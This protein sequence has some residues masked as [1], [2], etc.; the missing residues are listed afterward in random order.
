MSLASI[1]GVAAPLLGALARASWQGALFI[2]AVWVLC[3]LARRLPAALRCA[4]WWTASVKLLVGLAWAA[5]LGLPLLPAA[6]RTARPAA[7]AQDSA[8]TEAPETS[9]A[10][11]AAR[12]A[13]G[14]AS[15][16]SG[17]VMDSAAHTTSTIPWRAVFSALS[18]GPAAPGPVVA[19]MLRA[20][21]RP[22]PGR[23][24]AWSSSFTGLAAA[25]WG[26]GVL[27]Q[28]GWLGRELRRCRSMVRASRPLAEPRA[29]ALVA[30]LRAELG[31][32]RPPVVRCSPRVGSPLIL[33]WPR[34]LVLLP[35][36]LAA[37]TDAELAMALGHELLHL[38]RRDLW[39]GWVPLLAERIFFFHPLAGLAAREYALAREAACDAEVVDRIAPA[40]R[41]YGRLLLKL[42]L[43]PDAAV[44]MS[45]GAA[46]AAPTGADNLKR[47]LQMLHESSLPARAPRRLAR[48]G[49]P[50][51]IV[52]LVVV[53]AACLV[54]FEIV[55][56]RADGAA[57]PQA[58]P[59]IQAAPEPAPLADASPAPAAASSPGIGSP[60]PGTGSPA[61][62]VASA[63]PRA[64]SPPPRAKFSQAA[65]RPIARAPRVRRSD[66]EDQEPILFVHGDS[67]EVM[68]GS[69]DSM[70]R[71]KT[72]RG[73]LGGGDLLWFR[74]GGKEYTVRDAATLKRVAEVL[75]PQEELGRQQGEL[76]GRQGALG[77]KQ[78]ELGAQ[79]GKLGA[80]QGELGAEQARLA[81]EESRRALEGEDR[82][83]RAE[84][85]RAHLE[86]EM[87][88]L[89]K[90]QEELGRRQE[91]LGRQ[92]E[93]LGQQQE[94]LGKLQ[95]EAAHKAR[96]QLRTL[97]D[98]ALASGTAQEV[99]TQ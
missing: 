13:A 87:E 95:E 40:P 44:A 98:Q 32:R 81:Q 70:D 7:A 9:A 14:R 21:P 54:P 39:W 82:D 51:L 29:I 56:Q 55:A 72:L 88:E 6:A 75:A 62:G 46:G 83:G 1:A 45:A 61:P 10:A 80:K 22:V 52:A 57:V 84:R 48:L 74:R 27:L 28:L 16:R 25:A 94:R 59:A 58:A 67:T 26:A 4:L 43:M 18:A 99:R 42:T 49:R 89:G 3:R 41:A 15:T 20:E 65:P 5:P 53:A 47:R 63:A 97:I 78:G 90:Q 92:Q 50:L 19:T 86:R 38:R 93:A 24:A 60:M 79:Q 34:P 31:L 73:K 37:W 35:Q 77:A 85:E 76:G 69:W 17:A 91:E 36:D 33:G 2:A 71:V 11:A 30:A 23:S 96:A 64:G 8:G 12:E 66:D 68:G